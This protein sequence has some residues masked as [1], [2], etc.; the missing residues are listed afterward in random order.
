MKILIN[1]NIEGE[2][3]GKIAKCRGCEKFIGWAKTTN[4]K[5]MPF[6]RDEKYTA[7]WA[8]CKRAGEFK[9]KK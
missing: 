8:S 1:G 2:W 6:D 9:S 4:G 5:W 7:H 3:N